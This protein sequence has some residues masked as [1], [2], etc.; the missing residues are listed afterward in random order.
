MDDAVHGIHVQIVRDEPGP[1][2]LDFMRARFQWLARESL[3]N[4]GRIDRLDR[5][6]LKTRP[7]LFD[8]FGNTGD[9]AAG[10]DRGD[11]K[12]DFPIGVVPDFLRRGCAVNGRVG[13]GC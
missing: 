9:G 7:P 5:D 1:G 2:T 6:G 3:R 11:E 12:I 8:H 10:A 4:D 13:R